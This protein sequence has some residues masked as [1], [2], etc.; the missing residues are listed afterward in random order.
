MIIRRQNGE[1]SM[2]AYRLGKWRKIHSGAKL[3]VQPDGLFG[4]VAEEI[5]S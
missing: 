2:E 3:P 5:F 4:T 1:S